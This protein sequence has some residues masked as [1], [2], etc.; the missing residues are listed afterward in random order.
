MAY[1]FAQQRPL[2]SFD[3]TLEPQPLL[4][5]VLN[6]TRMAQSCHYPQINSLALILLCLIFENLILILVFSLFLYAFEYGVI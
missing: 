6:L 4:I 3:A 2:P 5:L 1:P